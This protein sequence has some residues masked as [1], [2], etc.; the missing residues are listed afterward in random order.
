MK[1][2]VVFFS[3][4]KAYAGTVAYIKISDDHFTHIHKRRLM[5]SFMLQPLYCQNGE[6]LIVLEAKC[7]Q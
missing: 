1:F 4:L 6:I 7:A 2:I 3:L 5:D